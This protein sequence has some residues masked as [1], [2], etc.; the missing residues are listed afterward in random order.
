MVN[1][2]KLQA[3]KHKWWYNKRRT[4]TNTPRINIIQTP[5]KN[6]N[7]KNL[8]PNERNDSRTIPEKNTLHSQ[9]ISEKIPCNFEWTIRNLINE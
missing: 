4:T 7:W 9:S 5:Q 8:N 3:V 1:A 6:M 2:I